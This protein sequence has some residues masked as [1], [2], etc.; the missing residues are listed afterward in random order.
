MDDDDMEA[1]FIQAKEEQEKADKDFEEEQ[2][3]TTTLEPEKL[4]LIYM[5][6]ESSNKDVT[7][8]VIDSKPK[9]RSRKA[10]QLPGGDRLTTQDKKLLKPGS[11]VQVVS[12]T[13]AE[14]SG[15]LK[16]L[17][18]KTGKVCCHHV[19]HLHF[20][21]LLLQKPAYYFQEDLKAVTYGV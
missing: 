17:D 6:S 3:R 14:F 19:N 18:H 20:D 4:N 12:G 16:Q 15:I 13:F 10:A 21:R 7:V 9:R 2:Q 1:I 11:T 5:D 8:S